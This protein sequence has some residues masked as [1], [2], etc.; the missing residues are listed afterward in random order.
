MTAWTSVPEGLRLNVRLQPNARSAAVEGLEQL[1]DGSYVLKV[2]VTAPPEDGKANR[3]LVELL[4]KTWR[5]PKRDLE[6]ISGH[7]ARNKGLLLHG[8]G[9]VLRRYLEE[10]YIPNT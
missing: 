10:L 8:D 2:R 6:L 5:R 3:A 9:E 7:K 4:A 1:S